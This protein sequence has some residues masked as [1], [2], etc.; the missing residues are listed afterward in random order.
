M[1]QGGDRATAMCPGAGNGGEKEEAQ[2]ITG[3]T[4][5]LTNLTN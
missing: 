2:L 5:D 3:T 4:S 1:Y